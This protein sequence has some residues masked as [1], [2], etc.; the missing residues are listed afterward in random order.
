VTKNVAQERLKKEVM[1]TTL[2]IF[3]RLGFWERR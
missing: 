3:Q 2:K 1:G